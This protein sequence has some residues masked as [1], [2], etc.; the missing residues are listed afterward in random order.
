MITLDRRKIVLGLAAG[1]APLP[2]PR[3]EAQANMAL[4]SFLNSLEYGGSSDAEVEV[5][6]SEAISTIMRN[7]KVYRQLIQDTNYELKFVINQNQILSVQVLRGNNEEFHIDY[8][9]QTR[10]IVMFHSHLRNTFS[11]ELEMGRY[12]FVDRAS[13]VASPKLEGI[14]IKYL[15]G[16]LF[17]I[18]H[19]G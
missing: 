8:D 17:R 4:E 1:T 3:L 11:N 15:T 19:S 7:N 5:I 18:L 13:I 6:Y 10:Q 9:L 14:L 16:M 2:I 12:R